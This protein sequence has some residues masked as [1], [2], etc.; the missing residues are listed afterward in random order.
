[1]HRCNVNQRLDNIQSKV[2]QL[3]KLVD[4]LVDGDPA[5]EEE[6]LLTLSTME[7]FEA[8]NERLRHDQAYRR[9]RVC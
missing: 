2:D 5:S 6:R 1:M 3:F 8:E 7:E 4:R 9:R